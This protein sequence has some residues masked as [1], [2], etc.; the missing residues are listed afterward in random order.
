MRFGHTSLRSNLEHV[1][2]SKQPWQTNIAQTTW[3]NGFK[4]LEGQSN[5]SLWTQ[6]D[7][8]QKDTAF[9]ETDVYN[10]KL[11][12]PP[13]KRVR[14]CTL[15]HQT[16]FKTL[17]QQFDIGEKSLAQL[18]YAMGRLCVRLNHKYGDFGGVITCA[19]LFFKQCQNVLLCVQ[20]QYFIS[21]F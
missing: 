17:C 3:N 20:T 12:Q 18:L 13:N 19:S 2:Y 11:G 21:L 7:Y 8:Q 16:K 10:H 15:V 5:A 9:V 1:L 6:I 14:K 4:H